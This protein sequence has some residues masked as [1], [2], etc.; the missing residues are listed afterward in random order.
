MM[1]HAAWGSSRCSAVIAFDKDIGALAVVAVAGPLGAEADDQR[2][3][4]QPQPRP[5]L[6]ALGRLRWPELLGLDTH[7]DADQLRGVDADRRKVIVPLPAYRHHGVASRLRL[8]AAMVLHVIDRRDARDLSLEL[9]EQERPDMGRQEVGDVH[10]IGQVAAPAHE[11][12]RTHCEQ[13]VGSIQGLWCAICRAIVAVTQKA[14][15]GTNKT[16]SF[17]P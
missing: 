1:R 17:E 10:A 8:D 2:F 4:R 13:I 15:S 16:R 6:R 3:R 9:G 11:S 7:G 12:G 5:L 14:E